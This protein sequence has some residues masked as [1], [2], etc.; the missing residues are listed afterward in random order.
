MHVAVIFS[1]V[2]IYLKCHPVIQ[3]SMVYWT[4]DSVSRTKRIFVMYVDAP[5]GAAEQY[6]DGVADSA[7][8][9]PYCECRPATCD[10]RIA[11]DTLGTSR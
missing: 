8:R 6:L 1:H 2:G 3:R 5:Y 7:C 4:S 10:W 9:V 11:W